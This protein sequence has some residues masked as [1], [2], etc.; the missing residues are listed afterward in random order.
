[1]AQD[2]IEIIT[3]FSAR[4][5]GSRSRKTKRPHNELTE[6]KEEESTE[7]PEYGSGAEEEEASE[8]VGDL[9]TGDGGVARQRA[10]AVVDAA[11]T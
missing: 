1:M 10:K 2:V 5:Y 8:I 4:L 11:G 6:R 7:A 3:V 9:L